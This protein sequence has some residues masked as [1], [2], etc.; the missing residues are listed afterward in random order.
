MVWACWRGWKKVNGRRWAAARPCDW[1]ILSHRPSSAREERQLWP[2]LDVPYQRVTGW[3][4]DGKLW[5][6]CSWAQNVKFG[7]I[8]E[9]GDNKW[10]SPACFVLNVLILVIC[11]FLLTISIVLFIC[12]NYCCLSR[13]HAFT[14][15]ATQ[16]AQD[17]KS[18]LSFQSEMGAL[19]V[20]KTAGNKSGGLRQAALL[21]AGALL[22]LPGLTSELFH[23]GSEL[24]LCV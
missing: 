4:W 15:A 2:W 1:H 10:R 13:S 9:D 23:G 19:K 3:R 6:L 7:Q 14:G 17:W 12:H 20:D 22:Q 21:K 16:M 5:P 11:H 18:L 8:Y 24:Y